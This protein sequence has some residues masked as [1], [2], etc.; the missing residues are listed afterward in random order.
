MTLCEN[1]PQPDHVWKKLKCWL[2]NLAKSY[3][4]E[5]AAVF[6]SKDLT[7][8]INDSPEENLVQ[9]QRNAWLL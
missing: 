8:W 4:P 9:I 2:D 1:V 6:T 5:K 3:V 7:A